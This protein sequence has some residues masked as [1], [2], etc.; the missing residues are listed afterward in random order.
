M[1]LQKERKTV[2]GKNYSRWAVIVPR[3]QIAELG[4]KEGDRLE[5]KIEGSKLITQSPAITEQ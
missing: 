1:R 5:Q 2:D 4:W 3:S